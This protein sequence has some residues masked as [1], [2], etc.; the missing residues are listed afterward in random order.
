MRR[1]YPFIVASLFPKRSIFSMW[2][3]MVKAA[4]GGNIITDLIVL[5]KNS[6][7][8]ILSHL[9]PDIVAN[10]PGY[11]TLCRMATNLQHPVHPVHYR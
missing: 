6:Q 9:G 7:E 5:T 4:F 10:A 2:H 3:G 8:F 11:E 1:M